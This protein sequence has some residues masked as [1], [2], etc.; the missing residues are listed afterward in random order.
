L[1]WVDFGVVVVVVL[2]PLAGG[3]V[4][5]ATDWPSAEAL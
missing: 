3:T 4:A 5:L 1:G 2:L